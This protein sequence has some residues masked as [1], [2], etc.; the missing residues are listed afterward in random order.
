[1]LVNFNLLANIIL[2][3]EVPNIKLAVIRAKTSKIFYFA[4]KNTTLCGIAFPNLGNNNP[5]IV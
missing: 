4:D 5:V 3:N 2:S 1:M